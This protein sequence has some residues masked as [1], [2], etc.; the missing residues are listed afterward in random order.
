MRQ[1]A[2][3]SFLLCSVFLLF[4]ILFNVDGGAAQTAEPSRERLIEDARGEGEVVWY[5]AM[6]SSDA[7]AVSELFRE[8]YPFLTVKLLRQPGEK[9]LRERK[10]S[11]ARIDLPGADPGE[12]K[13]LTLNDV[14]PKLSRDDD[15]YEKEFHEIFLKN[16]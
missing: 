16:R 8:K 12:T 3:S 9:V 1:T 2:R 10:R 13:A 6:N 4:P 14:S 7:E 11:P 15:R 5:T